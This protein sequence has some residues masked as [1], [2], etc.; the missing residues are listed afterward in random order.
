MIKILEKIPKN[1]DIRK[2]NMV[3]YKKQFCCNYQKKKFKS[4][5]LKTNQKSLNL[6]EEELNPTSPKEF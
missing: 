3:L 1:L 5:N 6:K 4:K 2:K